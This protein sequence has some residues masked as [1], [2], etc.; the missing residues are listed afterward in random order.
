MTNAIVPTDASA[1]IAS[2]DGYVAQIVADV[3]AKALATEKRG[4]NVETRKAALMAALAKANKK[5]KGGS[6]D[7]APAATAAKSLPAKSK[8]LAAFVES[9]TEVGLNEEQAVVLLDQMLD[10]KLVKELID[11]TYDAAK[12]A[13]FASMTLAA[14]E[15][16]EEFPE[17]INMVLDVPELG[18]RFCREGAGRKSATLDTEKLAE[19]VG[20]EGWEAIT[21]EQVIPATVVRVIDEAK[22]AAVVAENPALLEQVREAVV[23]GDWKTPR[24]SI[25]D[26]PATEKKE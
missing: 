13:V 1:L 9:A 22:L 16:G 25:R 20:A 8:A 5:V 6:A 11:A 12:A 2:L 23:P 3:D 24:L 18:K 10:A 4:S 7:L 19:L 17:N 15:E 26:I 14:A 21:T